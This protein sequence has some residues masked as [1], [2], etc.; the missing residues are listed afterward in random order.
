[1]DNKKFGIVIVVILVGLLIT[2]CF[3]G[4]D[5]PGKKTSNVMTED[6]NV[7]L[8]NAERESNAVTDE[9][10]GEFNQINIDE[11]LDMYE[12]SDKDIVLIARPTCGYCTVATPIIQKLIKEYDLDVNYLNTDNFDNDGNSKLVASDEFFSEGYG[13]PLL[14]VVSDNSI[15]DK[16]DGLTD[17]AHY[18]EFFKTNG[19]IK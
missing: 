14:V 13:T 9:E 11:Y 17:T 2:S 3:I 6:V 15:V 1:M 12:S 5:K 8:A 18:L 16:V 10:K 4:N 19:F 7:I